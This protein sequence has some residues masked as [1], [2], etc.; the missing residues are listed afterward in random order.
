M[1]DIV[2]TDIIIEIAYRAKNTD[3]GG[4]ISHEQQYVNY[5]VTRTKLK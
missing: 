4:W 2:D 1:W 3:I 5:W